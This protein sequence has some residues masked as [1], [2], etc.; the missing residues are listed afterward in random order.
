MVVGQKK[1]D[2]YSLLLKD[3]CRMQKE[4]LQ[5]YSA[6]DLLGKDSV[7]QNAR[8][9][10]INKLSMEMF[11]YWYGTQWDYNGMTR[12]P[13]EGKISCGYFVTNILTDLG[14]LIPRIKWAQ[15]AS[16]VFIKKLSIESEIKRFIN[17]P[18][19][20]VEAYLKSAGNGIYLVGLDIHVGFIIVSEGNI[21]FIHS[22]YYKPQIGVMSENITSWNPL[23][24]SKYRIIGKLMSDEMVKN[25]I[26]GFKY[27]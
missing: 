5:K 4:Y 12:I 21:K 2:D 24:D 20:E 15:S 16:E 27:E 3:I 8:E 22:N 17:K 1:S 14:F 19:L 18:I 13:N 26:S 23:R 11:P 6:A 9:Y 7:V 10:L 25:W